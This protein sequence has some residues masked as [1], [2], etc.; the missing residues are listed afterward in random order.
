MWQKLDLRTRILMGYGMIVLLTAILGG[1]LV[2]RV[3]SLS[4]QI[5]QLNSAVAAEVDVGVRLADRVA[6]AQ[7]AVDRYLQQPQ[8]DHLLKAQIAL[9][10]L[11]IEIQDSAPRLSDPLQQQRLAN[12]AVETQQYQA[13]FEALSDLI[14]AQGP[15]LSSLELALGRSKQ[16]L[17]DITVDTLRNNASPATTRTLQESMARLDSVSMRIVRLAAVQAPDPR[18]GPSA[19]LDQIRAALDELSLGAADLNSATQGLILAS[20]Y[21]EQLQQ[22]LR[23]LHQE[24]ASLQNERGSLLQDETQQIVA[25]AMARLNDTSA[26][27]ER[28]VGQ[29]LQFAAAILIIIIGLAIVSGGRIAM[30]I[31]QPLHTMAAATLQINQGNYDV[32]VPDRDGSEIGRLANA[33][34]QMA[35]TLKAQRATVQRQQET[36]TERNADLEQAL[37]AIQAASVERETLTTAMRELSVPVVPILPGVIALP[38]VGAIDSIRAQLLLDQLLCG[39]TDHKARTAI[40]DVTGVPVVDLTVAEWLLKAAHAARLLGAR[41]VMVGINPEM[42]Q[43]MVASGAEFA[44]IET[45]SDMQSA[46][47]RALHAGAT[48]ARQPAAPLR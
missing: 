44:T 9:R 12:L 36:L 8:M 37:H 32:H 3:Y 10:D 43:A 30:L 35:A 22:N 24:R 6:S 15:I 31:A 2:A 21:T 39:V 13:S 20:G 34:N 29:I 33:F 5:G 23:Q 1:V 7:L 11:T 16:V 18:T 46:V 17:S 40:L 4:R 28:Q 14:H 19:E 26:N 41:C 48:S 45:R 47:L 27:L 42:A 38:L 25:S